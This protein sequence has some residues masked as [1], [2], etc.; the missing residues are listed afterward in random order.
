VTTNTIPTLDSHQR[1]SA[2]KIVTLS[3]APFIAEVISCIH[4]K[5]SIIQISKTK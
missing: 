4:T 5:G 1:D 3:V 2:S